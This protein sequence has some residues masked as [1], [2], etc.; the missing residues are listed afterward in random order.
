MKSTKDFLSIWAFS[1]KNWMRFEPSLRR[2]QS[3]I[4][5]CF[6]H[7]EGVSNY[8][9]IK[10]VSEK[11]IPIYFDIIFDMRDKKSNN[12]LRSLKSQTNINFPVMIP[13]YLFSTFANW[14]F[15]VRYP[16]VFF[17]FRSPQTLTY[18]GADV[19]LYVHKH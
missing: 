9:S 7:Q 11:I 15:F 16:R 4:A 1:Q 8:L 5:E 19:I 13:H 2:H 18:C 10:S 3:T 6:F 17:S 12:N 14:N